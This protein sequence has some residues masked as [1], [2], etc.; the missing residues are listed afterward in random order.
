MPLSPEA[1]ARRR[2]SSR[3]YSQR[4]RAKS[5]ARWKLV[6]IE[7]RRA[8]GRKAQAKRRREH[9]EAVA[10]YEQ[11]GRDKRRKSLR[12]VLV[13]AKTVPCLDCGNS[14][15]YCAME[16]DH[17]RGKKAFS[18]SAESSQRSYI[19][20]AAEI[21]KCDVVC[22]NCHRIRT[23]IRHQHGTGVRACPIH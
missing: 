2:E 10:K 13:A 16:F 1:A 22:A 14:Y 4:N 8:I 15:P 5:T 7:I 9:P 20:L 17:T 6:P 3:L 12:E 21:E 11:A 18:V 23:C 19:K